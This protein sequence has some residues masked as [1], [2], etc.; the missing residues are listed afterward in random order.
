MS[1][2]VEGGF[3]AIAAAPPTARLLL[4][5]IGVFCTAINF[6][7]WFWALKYVTAARA[8]PIQYLS[9]PLSVVLAWYALGEPL[10]VGLAV[11]TLLVLLGV[12]LTQSGRRRRRAKPV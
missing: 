6:G 2:A 7:L 3:G 12:F 11:G 5:Y 4:L 9:T 10:T 8:A 1:V